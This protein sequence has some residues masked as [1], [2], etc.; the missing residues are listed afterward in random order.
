VQDCFPDRKFSFVEQTP[1]V[2]MGRTKKDVAQ[3]VEIVEELNPELKA[4]PL[5]RY[6]L[7]AWEGTIV[8]YS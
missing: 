2:V 4:T 1:E 7:E 8:H 5:P 6:P 3:A